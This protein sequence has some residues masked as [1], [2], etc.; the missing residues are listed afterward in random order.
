MGQEWPPPYELT[1]EEFDAGPAAFDEALGA[2]GEG[3]EQR[4]VFAFDVIGAG[5]AQCGCG[6]PGVV[7][8]R[9]AIIAPS[10]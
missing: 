5:A 10:E 1:F 3:V 9:P 8:S 2:D 7:S 6:H 4:L